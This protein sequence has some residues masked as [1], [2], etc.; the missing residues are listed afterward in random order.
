MTA[1]FEQSELLGRLLRWRDSG[2]TVHLVNASQEA[3]TVELRSCSGEL[4]EVVATSD[5]ALLQQV[6]DIT[7]TPAV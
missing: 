3:A 7:S 1:E 5:S 4:M 2:G 6:V